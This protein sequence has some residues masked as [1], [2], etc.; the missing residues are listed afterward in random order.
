MPSAPYEDQ[1]L[2]CAIVTP[3]YDTDEVFYRFRWFRD[4]VFAKDLGEST[5]VPAALTS[6]GEVWT[7]RVRASDGIEFSPEVEAIDTVQAGDAP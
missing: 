7:C 4:G 1:D 6:A 2:A 3:S 5:V